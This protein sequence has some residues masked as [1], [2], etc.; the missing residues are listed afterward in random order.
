MEIDLEV[1]RLVIKAVGKKGGQPFAE[2]D[3]T[4]PSKAQ[5]FEKLTGLLTVMLVNKDVEIPVAPIGGSA[6]QSLADRGPFEH[7]DRYASASKVIGDDGEA[8]QAA[9]GDRCLPG[10][11]RGDQVLNP[12]S[13]VPWGRRRDEMSEKRAHFVP[14][15][16][17]G[18]DL[19]IDATRRERVSA[20]TNRVP[21]GDAEVTRRA[22]EICPRLRR[23]AHVGHGFG[24]R[25]RQPER[26][27]GTITKDC[28]PNH[29]LSCRRGK[30]PPAVLAE[31]EQ[32]WVVPLQLF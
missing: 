20:L 22:A 9:I 2:E 24:R 19:T 15:D 25:C 3:R 10:R 13:D 31:G 18:D 29:R 1:A 32:L 12:G 8:V 28:N 14:V 17:H 27:R 30:I 21:Q 5:T 11:R 16:E 26:R 23:P 6:E 7:H 4:C